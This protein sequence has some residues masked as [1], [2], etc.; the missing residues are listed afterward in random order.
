[1]VYHICKE[2]DLKLKCDKIISMNTYA[3]NNDIILIGASVFLKSESVLIIGDIHLGLEEELNQRGVLIPRQELNINL[4]KIEE[5]LGTLQKKKLKVKTLIVNG[6]LKHDF[7]TI[8]QQEWREIN[9]FLD[10]LN[11][12]FERVILVKGN[13]DNLLEPI[14]RKRS[15]DMKNYVM[16][17]DKLITHGHKIYKI[18]YRHDIKTI[19]IG[20]EHPAIILD[21]GIR[22]ETFKTFLI[23]KWRRKTLIVM[24]SFCSVTVGS[25]VR[26]G[27]ISPF[28][29]ESKL[30][31]FKVIVLGDKLYNFGK[32]KEI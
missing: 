19:I 31:R 3:L 26:E 22:K 29:S 30:Q 28:L 17:K 6:D 13:H 20:H 5:I 24:P 25:D 14:I 23:G 10:F 2:K 15:L 21:D 1:M 18:S 9:K 12:K 4:K 27:T 32:L 16:I 7:G 8:N 11:K